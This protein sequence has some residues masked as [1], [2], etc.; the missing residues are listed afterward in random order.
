MW[1]VAIMSDKRGLEEE[2]AM[3]TCNSDKNAM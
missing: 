2:A 1:L 3:L